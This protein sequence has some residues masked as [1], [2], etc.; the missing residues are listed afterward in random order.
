MTLLHDAVGQS[1]VCDYG[2]SLSYLLIFL[3]LVADL[4]YSIDGLYSLK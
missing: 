1:G 4:L 2:I 3:L